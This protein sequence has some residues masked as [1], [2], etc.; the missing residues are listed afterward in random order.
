MRV[1]IFGTNYVA[2]SERVWLIEQWMRLHVALNAGCNI[3][4][5]DSASPK[6]WGNVIRWD[7]RGKTFV[8]GCEVSAF[9]DN[10]GH[11]ARGGR[12]GWGRAFCYGLQA[13]IDGGYDYVVHI[14]GDS[15]FRLPVMP[16]IEQMR[17]GGIRCASVPVR[18]TKRLETDWVE[19]GLMFFEVA[20]L[21]EQSIVQRYNWEEC[22]PKR[23]YPHCPEWHMHGIVAPE[24]RLMPWRAERGDKNQ[25]T[26]DNVA[27][28]DWI[29]HCA[30]EVYDRFVGGTLNAVA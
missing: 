26:V 29:T 13:A 15:L 19:T 12:D 16:I 27:E 24:L 10:I 18:G 30:P 14:E 1:L 23:R 4:I 6:I 5:V 7:G 8:D 2:T 21:A 28:F 22:E 9:P 11:L 3:L 17:T 25:I 20:Y